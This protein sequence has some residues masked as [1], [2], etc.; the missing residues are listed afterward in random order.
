MGVET[1]GDLAGFFNP[2]EFGVRLAIAGLGAF[3]G[4]DTTGFTS[5]DPAGISAGVTAVVPRIICRR[6]AV[7]DIQQ[8]DVIEFLDASPHN[9]AGALVTVNDLQFKGAL[10]VIHYHTE[11]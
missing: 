1:E 11:F 7:P 5:L 4:I 9:A 8:G 10:L 6:A 3:N 2:D